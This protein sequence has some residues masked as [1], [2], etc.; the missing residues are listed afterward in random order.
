MQRLRST[1]T[2]LRGATLTRLSSTLSGSATSSGFTS[3]T[4]T[5]EWAQIG[6]ARRLRSPFRRRAK[7]ACSLFPPLCL[8]T[9]VWVCLPVSFS[10]DSFCFA[11]C[12]DTHQREVALFYKLSR[13]YTCALHPLD[14]CLVLR[15][16]AVSFSCPLYSL[17]SL[18]A[19]VLDRF[20]KL[21]NTS[22]LL[23]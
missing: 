6:T 14:I 9:S 18:V 7:S 3:D 23:M 20:F 22:S 15:D 13:V 10:L 16:N 19:S 12:V 1:K 4:T 11:E 21:I 8:S 5:R 17:L 2:S